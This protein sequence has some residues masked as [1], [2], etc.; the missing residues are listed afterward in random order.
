M[1]AAA[2]RKSP[3][4]G[5][6]YPDDRAEL[7]H[8]LDQAFEASVRRT[9]GSPRPGGVAFIAPHAAPMYSGAVAAAVYRHAAVRNPRRVIVLGFLHSGRGRGIDMPDVSAISTPLGEV[10]VDRRTMEAA[11]GHAAFRIDGNVC[12]HSVEIQLPFIQY[13]LPGA[14]VVPMYV[15]GLAPDQ[16]VEA[17][18]V[19]RSVLDDDAVLIASSDLTHYG[20]GFGYLPFPVNSETPERLRDLDR[21]VMD[22][23]GSVDPGV[24]LEELRRS[25]S[26]ACGYDP[27]ALLLAT[28]RGLPGEEIFAEKLDYQTS[29]EITG[30]WSHSVSYGALGYFPA[31]AFRIDEGDQARLIESA[32]RTLDRLQRTGE[33]I[34]A[35]PA[36]SEALE[37]RA[38]VFVT[39]YANGDVRGCVGR[40]IDCMP[41]AEAVPQLTLSSALDDYRF[42][43]VGAGEKLEIEMHILTPMKRVR[44]AEQLIAGEHGGY[45]EYGA[46]R[47]LL[48]P[49]VASERGWNREQFVRA[50]AA[51][52]GLA[53]NMYAD[54]R[55]RLYVFRDQVFGDRAALVKKQYA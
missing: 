29:G 19:L 17:A 25:G 1:S 23:A 39:L 36:K 12:D 24:F 52:A 3:F 20:R 30:D 42:D 16:R 50:L 32:R 54:D 45:L 26:T 53:A 34:P 38:G 15:G 27:I 10:V 49:G 8:I 35:P 46:C 4:S 31:S 22:A 48:L 55:S 28:L 11:A 7:I 18:K 40:C 9:G 44:N 43:A 37:R 5:A 21:R 6:W 14:T 33:R 13:A 51:K 41:I 47:G 2:A